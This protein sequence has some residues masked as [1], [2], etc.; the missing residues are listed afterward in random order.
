MGEHFGV[1]QALFIEL[2]QPLQAGDDALVGQ[3]VDDLLVVGDDV[4]IGVVAKAECAQQD[5]DI[6]V[7]AVHDEGQGQAVGLGGLEGA[8]HFGQLVGRGGHIQSQLSKP[9]LVDIRNAADGLDGLLA[10]A[11]LLDPGEAVDVAVRRGDQG[12]VFRIIVQHLL[13]VGHV[14]VDQLVHGDDR[15]IVGVA[16]HVVLAH[17]RVEHHVGQV[18][19]GEDQVLGLTELVVHIA[20][21]VYDDVGALLQALVDQALAE[22]LRREGRRMGDGGDGHGFRQRELNALGETRRGH[23][24]RENQSDGCEKLLHGN[25]SFVCRIDSMS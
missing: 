23:E 16:Q 22:V 8:Q 10:L 7:A 25:I 5:A 13:Q 11:Q 15:A 9:R 12:T 17:L 3:G 19:A 4:M 1:D 2:V 14:I 21:P 24:Q 6:L 20:R 18:L